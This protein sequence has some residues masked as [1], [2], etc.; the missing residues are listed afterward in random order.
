MNGLL[1]FF[2][3]IVPASLLAGFAVAVAGGR[4]IGPARRHW[5]FV[6]SASLSCAA[7]CAVLAIIADSQGPASTTVPLFHW[8]NGIY[9]AAIDVP[10]ALFVDRLSALVLVLVTLAGSL[11]AMSVGPS[12][13]ERANGPAEEAALSL[14]LFAATIFLLSA[15]FAQMFLFWQL[16]TIAVCWLFWASSADGLPAARKFLLLGAAADIPFAI[17]LLIVWFHFD[18]FDQ[19]RLLGDAELLAATARDN[20]ATMTTLCLCFLAPVAARCA[21]FPLFGWL[22]DASRAPSIANAVLQS[23]VIVPTAV[24]LLLRIHPMLAAS[25]DARVFIAFVGGITAVLAAASAASERDLRRVLSFSTPA[26]VGVMLIGLASGIWLGFAASLLFLLVHSM[27]KT[28]LWLTCR[29]SRRTFL[30]PVCAVVLTSGLWGQQAAMSAVSQAAAVTTQRAFVFAYWSI[31]VSTALVAFALF[32]AFLMPASA[33]ISSA[34]KIEQEGGFRTTFPAW[35]AAAIAALGPPI[36]AGLAPWLPEFLLPVWSGVADG[37][38]EG[39]HVVL[40]TPGSGVELM[41]ML[42][43]LLAAWTWRSRYADRPP[44]E[45]SFAR[46]SRHRFYLNETLAAAVV[47]PARVAA[48]ICQVCDRLLVD[49][50]FAT[51]PAR[52]PMVVASATQAMRNGLVQF[53]C[54]SIL[55]AVGVL[56]A[57]MLWFKS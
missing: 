18:S 52:L 2:V 45:N 50:L 5:V 19:F 3:I 10:I 17:G 47:L 16:A 31:P 9:D 43:G 42:L 14:T 39:G 4:F 56:L 38:G 53:Y 22:D 11:V 51:L 8:M 36:L 44:S 25:P 33:E 6:A 26:F 32:R 49:S 7:A 20:P 29:E 35:I 28:A 13:G 12:K 34:P 40:F 27:A 57:A 1:D 24:Y 48:R 37:A 23:A 46:L 41:A 21:Q 54:L 55:A 30:L 15:N